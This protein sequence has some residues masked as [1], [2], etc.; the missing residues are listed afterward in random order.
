MYVFSTRTTRSFV[1]TAKVSV[2]R[3]DSLREGE[4]PIFAKCTYVWVVR[5]MFPGLRNLSTYVLPLGILRIPLTRLG[6][7]SLDSSYRLKLVPS[8]LGMGWTLSMKL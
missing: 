8:V 2:G 1:L 3:T 4:I 5:T 7:Y 6:F